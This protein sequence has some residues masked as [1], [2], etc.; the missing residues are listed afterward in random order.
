LILVRSLA[1]QQNSVILAVGNMYQKLPESKAQLNR[2]GTNTEIHDWVLYVD[3]VTG[4]PDL[5]K[6][7][8][9]EMDKS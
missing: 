9:F 6:S 3:V 7:V 2:Q 4:N 1:S 5:I 8:Q